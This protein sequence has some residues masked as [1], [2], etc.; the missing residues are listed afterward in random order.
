MG[1][2]DLIPRSFCSL[3]FVVTEVWNCEY[4]ETCKREGK[5]HNTHDGIECD[6]GWDKIDTKCDIGP[7]LEATFYKWN[8]E[9]EPTESFPDIEFIAKPV[10]SYPELRENF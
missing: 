8:K 4:Y 6:T 9:Y 5:A 3:Y 7:F 10:A 2:E 1:E